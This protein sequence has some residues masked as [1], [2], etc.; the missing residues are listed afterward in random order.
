M[1]LERYLQLTAALVTVIAVLIV[2]FSTFY[3]FS[4]ITSL[5]TALMVVILVII[6]FLMT[7]LIY[8]NPTLFVISLFGF[9]ASGKTVFITVLFDKLQT[10]EIPG[11][12]FA[13][14]GDETIEQV[15]RN[16]S[17]LSSGE[18]LPPTVP[19]ELLFYRAK[20]SLGS[21]ISRRRFKLEIADYAGEHT[22]EFIPESD[23]WLHKTKYFRTIIQSD[24]VFMCIDTNVLLSKDS[25]PIEEMQKQLVTAFQILVQEKGIGPEKRMTSPFALLFL[26]ADLI[27]TQSEEAYRAL[28]NK[29]AR[30]EAICQ[31]RCRN[32]EVFFISSVGKIEKYDSPP[33]VRE[34]FGVIE[35]ILWVLKKV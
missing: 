1:K 33:R 4:L 35:P 3:K 25:A 14:Y 24:A 28:R 5:S 23:K 9:P 21:G 19:T 29:V 7:T 2:A 6:L 31:K 27:E 13:P 8:R 32:F 11:I 17:T 34:P 18:W 22:D 30:L 20:A 12:R 10:E 16:L 26:K 15:E